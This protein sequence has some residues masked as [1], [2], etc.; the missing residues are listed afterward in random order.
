MIYRQVAAK[1]FSKILVAIHE[2]GASTTD[3]VTDYAIKIAQDYDAHLVILHVIRT[4]FNLH[5]VNIPRHVME[6]R[7][8]VQPYFSKIAEKI[9]EDSIKENILR[10]KTEIIASVRIADA[11]I[12]Y[13][14]DKHTELIIIGTRNR[15]KLKSM[16]LGSVATDVVK[17]AP[18]PVLTVK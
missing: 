9:H 1:T 15:S 2:A 17:Y 16:L 8:Q 11:I 14:K 13:A 5:D 6:M 4:D 10:I 18:C 3:T 7:K 12:S